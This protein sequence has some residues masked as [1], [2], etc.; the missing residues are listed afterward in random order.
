MTVR[1]Q[2]LDNTILAPF[3][4]PILPRFSQIFPKIFPEITYKLKGCSLDKTP[5][6][7]VELCS[8]SDN[9]H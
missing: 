1:C 4:A 9:T 2:S 3:S 7:L 5:R 6:T 8:I